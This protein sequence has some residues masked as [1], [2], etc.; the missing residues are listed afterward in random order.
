MAKLQKGTTFL[1]GNTYQDSD[2][3]NLVDNATI[4]PGAITEQTAGTPVSADS[5]LFYSVSAAN[6]R[7]CTLTDIVG[8]FPVDQAAGT[9]S[10]RT[11]GTSATQA[12]AGNDSRFPATLTGIRRANGAGADTVA[13]PNQFAFNAVALAGGASVDWAAADMFTDSLSADRTFTFANV[14]NGRQIILALNMNGHTATFP[15]I[16]GGS[17]TPSNTVGIHIF[18]FAKAGTWLLASAS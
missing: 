14:T 9:A 16:N 11:L 18:T 17:V 15:S 5:F 12:A 2:F 6:L 4:L 10:L 3:N 7:K 13:T 8:A 1:N